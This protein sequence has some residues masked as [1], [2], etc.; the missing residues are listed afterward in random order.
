MLR[1]SCGTVRDEDP[2]DQVSD[3][4]ISSLESFSVLS[5]EDVTDSHLLPTY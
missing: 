3:R 2:L 4:Y 1:C 5:E